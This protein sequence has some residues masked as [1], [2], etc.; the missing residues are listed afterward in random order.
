M[1]TGYEGDFERRNASV[2]SLGFTNQLKSSKN[3]AQPIEEFNLFNEKVE[4]PTSTVNLAAG[5]DDARSQNSQHSG[6]QNDLKSFRSRGMRSPQ[7]RWRTA[8][9]SAVLNAVRKQLLVYYDKFGGFAEFIQSD[10]DREL[11]LKLV[12]GAPDKERKRDATPQEQLQ[13]Q[14][15]DN[16]TDRQTHSETKS[17]LPVAHRAE[18]ITQKRER[19]TIMSMDQASALQLRD[20]EDK[21]Q[22]NDIRTGQRLNEYGNEPVQSMSKDCRT[23]PVRPVVDKSKYLSKGSSTSNNAR[24]SRNRG[25]GLAA[26]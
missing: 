2:P 17:A 13:T 10:A 24:G 3:P 21:P 1:R 16:G 8:A 23:S 15:S 12:V 11:L 6:S 5:E 26:G 7:G 4:P 25:V 18:H 14:K 20:Q 19:S 22:L 9:A